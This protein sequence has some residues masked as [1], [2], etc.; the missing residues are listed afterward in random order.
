MIIVKGTR[1]GGAQRAP[2]EIYR[3][4]D[5]KPG[6]RI[7]ALVSASLAGALAFLAAGTTGAEAKPEP[8]PG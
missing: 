1:A 4:H 8:P 6:G 7:A 5:E 3:T 2:A